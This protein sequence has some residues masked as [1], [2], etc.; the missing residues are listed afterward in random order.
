MVYDRTTVREPA[1][2]G[3]T[4]RSIGKRRRADAV[5]RVLERRDWVAPRELLFGV[6]RAWF[7]ANGRRVSRAVSMSSL[8][9]RTVPPRELTVAALPVSGRANHEVPHLR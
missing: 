4:C 8:P 5:R 9:A 1:M 6:E 2:P 3:L 7:I